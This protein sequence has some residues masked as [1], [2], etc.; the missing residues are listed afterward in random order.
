MEAAIKCGQQDKIPSPSQTKPQGENAC[1]LCV[2][3]REGFL[4]VKCWHLLQ[5]LAGLECDT[6]LYTKGLAPFSRHKKTSIC[7]A[8]HSTG[9]THVW[10]GSITAP[11]FL[12]PTLTLI[13]TA[14]CFLHTFMLEWRL[15]CSFFEVD[16]SQLCGSGG[17]LLQHCIT[18]LAQWVQYV[19]HSLLIVVSVLKRAHRRDTRVDV[20]NNRM[21]GTTW[22]AADE[23]E[24]QAGE[25]GN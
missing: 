23:V 18:C 10:N 20:A 9:V 2:R 19:W 5:A 12:Y 25:K 1:V 17:E 21:G 14:K 16:V 11:C 3:R 6:L 4:Y 7:S 8:P 24:Q 13:K 15:L 22:N